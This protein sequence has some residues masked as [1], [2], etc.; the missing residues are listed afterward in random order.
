MT[1]PRDETVLLH[2]PRCSKSRRTKELLEE[3]GAAFRVRLYLEEPLSLDEL[4]DLG[5]R[6][7]RPAGEWTRQKEAAFA[8][9]GLT[10]GSDEE[11]ILAGMADHPILMERPILVCGDRAAIGRPPEDVLELLG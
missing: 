9:A 5:K 7:G 10:A 1:L 3:R 4:R 8:E 6:L 11:A 2:N